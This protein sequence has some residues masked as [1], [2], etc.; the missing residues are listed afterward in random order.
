MKR[1]ISLILAVA[2]IVSSFAFAGCQ[3]WRRVEQGSTNVNVNM[4]Q[5]KA[6]DKNPNEQPK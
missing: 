1:T 4:A 5:E 3:T 2:F 6:P